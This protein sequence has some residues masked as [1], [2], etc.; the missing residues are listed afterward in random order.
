MRPRE[1]IVVAAQNRPGEAIT[2][3]DPAAGAEVWPEE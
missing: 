1:M 3:Y 2:L